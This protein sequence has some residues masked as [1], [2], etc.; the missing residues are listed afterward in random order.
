MESRNLPGDLP[1]LVRALL[2]GIT[3]D[4]QTRRTEMCIKQDREH[5]DISSLAAAL[6]SSNSLHKPIS[7]H[8][9]Q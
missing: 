1:S 6:P 9:S 8:V 7:N 2:L 4:S 5:C 3:H